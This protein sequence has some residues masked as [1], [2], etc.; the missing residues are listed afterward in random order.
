MPQKGKK[1]KDKKDSSRKRGQTEQTIPER[2]AELRE[3][4]RII[5]SGEGGVAESEVNIRLELET[6]IQVHE[7]ETEAAAAAE[8]MFQDLIAEE[9]ASRRKTVAKKK[10]PQQAT[11]AAA[12][13][14][15]SPGISD[16]DD[17]D[18]DP[19]GLGMLMDRASQISYQETK[20][21]ELAARRGKTTDTGYKPPSEKEIEEQIR[22]SRR[23]LQEISQDLVGSISIKFFTT[24]QGV[25][26]TGSVPTAGGNQYI[27]GLHVDRKPTAGARVLVTPYNNPHRGSHFHL[28]RNSGAGTGMGVRIYLRLHNIDRVFSI[29]QD[30]LSA[31]RGAQTVMV[32]ERRGSGDKAGTPAQPTQMPATIDPVGASR[33]AS[34]VIDIL[35]QQFGVNISSVGNRQDLA[36]Q[37][38]AYIATLA[39]LYERGEAAVR[40]VRPPARGRKTRKRKR[41][42]THRRK[43]R[44]HKTRKH[45]TRKH[46]T[47]RRH[48]HK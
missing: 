3:T 29:Q 38:S 17:D 39:Y 40:G 26:V 14:A 28:W 43:T 35:E 20:T 12:A 42:K 10:T 5:E 34:E 30:Y 25:S 7:R 21:A 31:G 2:I 41:H 45:K 33:I 4:L 24:G 23:S 18:D 27:I 19:D 44:R 32:T 22:I 6:L 9:E 13:A 36:L 16:D 8:A 48:Q 46:K 1:K 15:A 47:M 37:L 11:S